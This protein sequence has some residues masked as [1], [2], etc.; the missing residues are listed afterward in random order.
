MATKIYYTLVTS[1]PRLVHFEQAE[2]LP[3]NHIRLQQRLRMLDPD[4]A[5]Q[6]ARAESLGI[7]TPTVS[8]RSG[9]DVLR[10]YRTLLTEPLH[11]SLRDYIDFALDQRTVLAALRIKQSG[12]EFP[13]DSTSWGIGRWVNWIHTHWDDEDFGLTPF[14]PWLSAAKQALEIGDALHLERLRLNACWEKLCRIGESNLFG[15]EAVIAFYFRWHILSIWLAHDA[16]K[17]KELFQKLVTEV[18][19]EKFE[20]SDS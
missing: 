18:I 20:N 6:L 15:F 12:G 13:G 5:A 17:S 14:Y 1:F 10:Q 3:I 8:I 19:H 2:L 9:E 11:P 4:H 7:W 16:H